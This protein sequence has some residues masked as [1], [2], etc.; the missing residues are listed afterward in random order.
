MR[1]DERATRVLTAFVLIVLIAL[2]TVGLAGCAGDD[3]GDEATGEADMKVPTA[4]RDEE[5]VPEPKEPETMVVTL[6]FSRGATGVAAVE[7]TVPY[8]EGVARVTMEEL[9]DGPNLADLRAEPTL[10]TEIPDGTILVDISV[11]HSTAKVDLS[12]DFASGGGSAS[13][14]TRVAQVVY[15]LAEFGTV[16]TVEFYS[17][18]VPL[19]TLG[20]EGLILDGPQRPQDYTTLVPIAR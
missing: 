10:G 5:R 4:Q 7:R 8:S 20:G 15:A 16:D 3:A 6:Y 14:L 13:M 1:I 17:G 18:G 9:L 12:A 11:Q 2:G 19:E